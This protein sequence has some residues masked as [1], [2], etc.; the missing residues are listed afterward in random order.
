MFG[1][2]VFVFEFWPF[3]YSEISSNGRHSNGKRITE[4]R[5]NFEPQQITQVKVQLPSISKTK[6]ILSTETNGGDV[7]HGKPLVGFSNAFPDFALNNL[8]FSSGDVW[9]TT[10]MLSTG[11]QT[12]L[13]QDIF[14]FKGLVTQSVYV[15][16]LVA[17]R[18]ISEFNRTK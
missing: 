8:H 5:P 4:A 13:G 16:S 12:H 7:A 6:V 17:P 1:F 3:L 15:S 11:A 14:G 9:T 2:D 10:K 18:A